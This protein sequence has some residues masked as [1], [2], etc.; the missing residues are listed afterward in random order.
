MIYLTGDWYWIITPF[1]PYWNWLLVLECL[2][3]FVLTGT[4]TQPPFI[5]PF[6]L[7]LVTGTGATHTPF[8]SPSHGTQRHAR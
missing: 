4:G 2:T 8:Y 7:V 3:G 1:I 5:P 6:P